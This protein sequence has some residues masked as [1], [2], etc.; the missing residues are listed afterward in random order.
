MFPSLYLA[1]RARL[2]ATVFSDTIATAF[3][4]IPAAFKGCNW[5]DYHNG[6]PEDLHDQYPI[7]LPALFIEFG[8][9][10]FQN[11]GSR[12]Q[13]ATIS[14]RVHTA[15]EIYTDTFLAQQNY[16]GLQPALTPTPNA[17]PNP[18]TTTDMLLLR[19]LVTAALH[20]FNPLPK[21]DPAVPNTTPL[22]TAA[23][24]LY[25]TCSLQHNNSFYESNYNNV[26]IDIDEFS[27]T[28]ERTLPVPFTPNNL[29]STFP[30][31]TD[32]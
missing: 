2:Q 4:T 18:T 9:T 7:P 15:Q 20:G 22:F 19:E 32:I 21:P 13:R 17:A 8:S 1:L 25:S 30:L 10:N 14:V 3:P 23:C 26:R 31:H 24:A 28:V 6:Q 16:T 11:H 27:V 5:I 29:T 12:L